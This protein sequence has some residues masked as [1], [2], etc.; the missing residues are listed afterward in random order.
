MGQDGV[1]CQSKAIT[2]WGVKCAVSL[3]PRGTFHGKGAFA[4]SRRGQRSA[5]PDPPIAHSTHSNGT[6]RTLHGVSDKGAT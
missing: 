6:S 5:A 1:I 2:A 4:T 3:E